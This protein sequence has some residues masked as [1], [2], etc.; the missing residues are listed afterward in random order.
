[1]A[2]ARLDYIDNDGHLRVHRHDTPADCRHKIAEMLGARLAGCERYRSG[3]ART[4]GEARDAH[5]LR[6]MDD[7]PTVN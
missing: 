5:D 3:K 1:M 6:P 4:W 7:P 2:S